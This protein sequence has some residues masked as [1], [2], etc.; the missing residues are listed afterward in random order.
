MRV[1]L[2]ARVS[3]KKGQQVENQ[4]PILEEWS[5]RNNFEAHLFV[6][7]ESTRKTRPVRE[8]IIQAMRKGEYDAIACV[9]L[10]RFLRSLSEVNLIK[11]LV[12]KNK[13][14]YFIQQGLEF[15]PNKD[16]AM[17]R[18][19]LG[20]LSVF[21]EFERDL[22]SER[23]LEGLERAKSENKILG[24]QK[25]SKDKGQR[26]KSGYW[27]RWAKKRGAENIILN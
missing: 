16:N 25:G 20:M 6:E 19:Q 13:S 26:R 17:S 9:R 15:S 18:M 5:K 12:D 11:E 24:R 14:F 3:K 10:D 21:A 1:A 2:Y 4:I 8:T 22:I 7:Q 23:T 27:L